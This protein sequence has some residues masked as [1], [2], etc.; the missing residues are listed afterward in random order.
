VVLDGRTGRP[1]SNA[2]TTAIAIFSSPLTVSMEGKG[3]DLFLYW[4]AGCKKIE[5]ESG[6]FNINTNSDET[7][8]CAKYGG[9][10]RSYTEL[11]VTNGKIGLSSGKLLYSSGKINFGF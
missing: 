3:N 7:K 11:Y 10:S 5:K 1:L 2:L 9:R 4:K 6:L 8:D